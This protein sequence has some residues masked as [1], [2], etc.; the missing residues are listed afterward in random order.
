[1]ATALAAIADAGGLSEFGDP[2]DWQREIRVDRAL[3]GR[4]E[5]EPD[6]DNIGLLT[7]HRSVRRDSRVTTVGVSPTG[8]LSF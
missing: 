8:Q 2:T 5:K 1:M 3:P 7:E 6:D 4:D